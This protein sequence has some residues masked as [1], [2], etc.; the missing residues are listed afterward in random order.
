[1]PF[2]TKDK[3]SLNS[4]IA[5]LLSESYCCETMQDLTNSVSG[6]VFHTNTGN[7]FIVEIIIYFMLIIMSTL[8][9]ALTN[10]ILL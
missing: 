10:I 7:K 5:N 6:V 1:M 2:V 4:S 3:M 9:L 8:R